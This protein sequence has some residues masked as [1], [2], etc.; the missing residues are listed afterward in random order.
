MKTS[1]S[2]V[3]LAKAMLKFQS[4]IGTIKKDAKNPHFKSNFASLSGILDSVSPVLNEVGLIVLQHPLGDG[5]S[6][7]L[8]T[9]LI[10]A[11]TGEFMS[12]EFYMK[13]SKTD[14]QGIGSCIT[15][16]RRYALGAILE[17][18]ID[19]DDGN[20]ASKKMYKTIA[21]KS[22]NPGDIQ[23]IVPVNQNKAASSQEMDYIIAHI[24]SAQTMDDLKE[25]GQEI[26]K[27]EKTETQRANLLTFY[28]ERME[29][30]KGGEGV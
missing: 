17:L 11:E 30:I 3:S 28:K 7:S 4:S 25:I 9:I 16:M 24:D 22:G 20:E 5:S 13:P 29:Y 26:A 2:I 23:E 14:P 12:S 21:N 8:E 15:Y 1:E 10:H 6:V 18:N 19:D 27:L